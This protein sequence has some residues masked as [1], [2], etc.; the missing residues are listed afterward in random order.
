MLNRYTNPQDLITDAMAHI[1]THPD[2]HDQEVWVCGTK[3]CLA[4][5]MALLDGQELAYTESDFQSRVGE[6]MSMHLADGTKIPTWARDVLGLSHMDEV[7][8]YAN[9]TVEQLRAGVKAYLNGD[10][11]IDAVSDVEDQ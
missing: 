2:E 3:A 11:I 6:Q 5:R 1:E 10:S 4:G 8:F 7:L 9:N